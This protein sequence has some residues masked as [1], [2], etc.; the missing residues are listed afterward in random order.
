MK[1]DIKSI[2]INE[3]RFTT[4]GD[5]F[6]D[7][8]GLHITIVKLDNE[9]YEYIVLMHE[10]TEYIICKFKGITS[11]ESDDFDYLWEEELKK[12]FFRFK[13]N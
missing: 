5:W 4:A 1:I 13:N 12:G 8:D 7:E 10:L 11:K 2:P 3:L 6:E 9:K